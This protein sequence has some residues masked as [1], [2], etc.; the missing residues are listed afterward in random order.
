M[1][2]EAGCDTRTIAAVLGHRSEVMARHY[3][4]EGDRRRRAVVA[5]RKLE[6]GTESGTESGTATR[7]VAAHDSALVFLLYQKGRDSR[8]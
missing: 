1:L 3:S 4:E 2:D 7:F 8:I 6:R 5:I